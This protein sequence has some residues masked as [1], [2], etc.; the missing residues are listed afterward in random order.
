M[1]ILD[2]GFSWIVCLVL[3]FLFGRTITFLNL[4]SFH[5]FYTARLIR[6]YQGA[7]NDDRW[8]AGKSIQEVDPRDDI[9]WESYAPHLNGGPLHL[10]NVAL[11]STVSTLTDM[12]STTTKGANL[13]VGPAGLSF[14]HRHAFNWLKNPSAI[15]ESQL[16]YVVPRQAPKER[17]EWRI[18]RGYRWLGARLGLWKP[19]PDLPALEQLPL[20]PDAGKVQRTVESL[21]LGEWVGISGAA[22]TTG[23]GNVGGGAGYKHWNEPALWS[24]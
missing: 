9:G 4:S 20:E 23:L 15:K 7:S 18:A 22:F 10:V 24:F 13:A 16:S 14:G 1:F 3:T 6:A 2:L 19:D 21:S 17:S 8:S 11:N 5:S 12:E